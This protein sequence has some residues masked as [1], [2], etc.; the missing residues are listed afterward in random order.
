MESLF[1]SQATVDDKERNLVLID[2][3]YHNLRLLTPRNQYII[4]SKL[5]TLGGV[6]IS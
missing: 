6:R 1:H 3:H 2:C 4:G 5:N